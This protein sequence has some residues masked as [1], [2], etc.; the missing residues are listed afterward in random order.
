[1]CNPALVTVVF[2]VAHWIIKQAAAKNK[3]TQIATKRTFDKWITWDLHCVK[4]DTRDRIFNSANGPVCV[5]ERDE[6]IQSTQSNSIN[7]RRE[8]SE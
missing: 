7:K 8:I 6:E 5:C 4:L 2:E 1:M 3:Y